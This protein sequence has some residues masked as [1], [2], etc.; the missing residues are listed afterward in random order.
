MTV[1]FSYAVIAQ[2]FWYGSVLD[3]DQHVSSAKCKL[4]SLIAIFSQLLRNMLTEIQQKTTN[5]GP[6]VLVWMMATL[7]PIPAT[8]GHRAWLRAHKCYSPWTLCQPTAHGINGQFRAGGQACPQHYMAWVWRNTPH[9]QGHSQLGTPFMSEHQQSDKTEQ[10]L[11]SD[12]SLY[13]VETF[14]SLLSLWFI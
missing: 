11:D 14:S 4:L 13:R 1:L 7:E 8:Y 3:L 12:G 9:I 5:K 6:L 10:K 2:C